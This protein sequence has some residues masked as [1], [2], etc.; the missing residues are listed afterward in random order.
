MADKQVSVRA[1][2]LQL[3]RG[4]AGRTALRGTY[5]YRLGL[6]VSKHLVL[7]P[8]TVLFLFPWYWMIITS[9]KTPDQILQ[10]PPRW[11]VHPITFRGYVEAFSQ[12]KMPLYSRN[13]FIICVANV[14]GAVLSNC[15]IAYAFALIKWPGRD[16]VFVLVLATM[17]LPYQVIMI[18]LFLIFHRLGWVNT[19]LPL[20]VPVYLGGPFYI[21]MLRQFFRTIPGEL[22]DA[23]RIDGCSEVGILWRVVLPLAKPAMAVVALFEF[24]WSWNDFL[25]PL[26]YVNQEELFT[27]SLG[28]RALRHRYA[29][30]GTMSV[31]MAAA[32]MSVIPVVILFFLTQR[33]FIEGITLTG[34]KGAA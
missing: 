29:G 27:L 21:F 9:L 22:T 34:L 11:I 1:T 7:L 12:A 8:L 23:A 3:R 17:M 13:T 15:S 19:Y 18:P 2:A 6:G 16:T 30:A 32:F 33:T 31:V 14:I 26:I 4:R 24:I 28:L 5:L 25:G 10:Y 20:I